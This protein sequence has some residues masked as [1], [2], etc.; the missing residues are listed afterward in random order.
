MSEFS[1]RYEPSPTITITSRSGFGHLGAPAAGDLVAHAGEAELAVEGA[2]GLGAPV[3]AQLARQA[4]GRGQRQVGRIA[5]PV[6][7]ADHMGIGRQLG[8]GR[9]R[10]LVDQRVPGGILVRC[11]RAPG[12][13]RRQ[14]AERCRQLG[15]AGLGVADDRERP[16]LGGIEAGGVQRDELDV[17]VGEHGPGAGGE[18]LQPRADREHDV[19]IGGER[20]GRGAADHAER[21]G[22]VRVVV[23]QAARPAMVSTTGTRCVSA[24]LASC[25]G[26]E[27]I[28]HAAAGDD[29]RPLRLAQRLRPRRPAARRPAA[30]AAPARP[31]A[32]RISP[33][34]RTPR[35]GRPG[36]A[37]MKAGPQSAGSSMV[38]TACGSEPHDLLGPGDAVPVARDRP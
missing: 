35:P 33:D 18:V 14:P 27:R 36:R 10:A 29:Q 28:V 6:D 8:V 26:R 11:P 2:D 13:R 23:R 15:K 25:L 1:I 21:A 24:K 12:G 20:I 9:A 17:R 22:I 32:R 16:V 34:S 31:S 19:G 7:R 5:G 3:L 38:A 4:A 37:P 30:A